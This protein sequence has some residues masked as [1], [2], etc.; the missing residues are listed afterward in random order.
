VISAEVM[1]HCAI[2]RRCA[3]EGA[4]GPPL[5]IFLL[6]VGVFAGTG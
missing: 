3:V 2:Y 6:H 4:T 5:R 1:S